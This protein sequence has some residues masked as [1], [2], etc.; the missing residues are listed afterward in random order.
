MKSLQVRWAFSLRKKLYLTP[1]FVEESW[2]LNFFYLQ[3]LTDSPPQSPAI[4]F[5]GQFSF[6]GYIEL[7]SVK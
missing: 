1:L 7:L 5:I 3:S 6:D 2:Y 4:V